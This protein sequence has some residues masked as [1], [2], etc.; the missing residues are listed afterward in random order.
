MAEAE[1]PPGTLRE[2]PAGAAHGAD[3]AP[4]AGS[5]PSRVRPA[6]L[7]EA[8]AALEAAAD[9]RQSLL[10]TGAGT[11][12]EWGAPV[13]ATDLVVETGGLDRLLGHAPEDWT[14]S[15]EA[16]MPL[17]R[18]QEQLAPAGQWLPLDAPTAAEGATLGGLLAGGDAGP[19][20]LKYGGMSDLVIG[21]TLVLADGT[22]VRSGGEVIK[23]VA[24]YDLAKLMSGSLGAFGLV[25]QLNLRVH[26]LPAATS[27]VALAEEDAGQALAA[28]RA[29]MRSPLEPVAVEWDGRRLLIRFHGTEESTAARGRLA[30]ALPELAAARVLDAAA[31]RSAWDELAARVRGR[32]GQTVLRAGTRPAQLPALHRTLR[33]LTEG[34]GVQAGIVS[35]I[36][37]GVHTVVLSGG[38]ARE[39]AAC[40]T[41][42]RESVHESGGSS[43]LRRRREGVEE[44]A[45]SW[46]PAP[47]AVPLLRSLKRE[48]DPDG[49]CAPGRFAPWF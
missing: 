15:A 35:G 39:H 26:P 21:A 47:P 37:Q 2:S 3:S 5:S 10:F 13:T 42:W 48:F 33:G 24:G 30:T 14:V 12:L 46:G 45:S 4:G 11:A 19:R 34:T 28:A 43:T 7:A 1:E 40:L 44:T 22:V 49:R 18:L 32:E 16:G 20:R 9:E 23:N 17:T 6:G 41:A 25:A 8:A 29:V 36:A 27:T 31:E 38:E